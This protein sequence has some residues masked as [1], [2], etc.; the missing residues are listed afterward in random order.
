MSGGC[1]SM[2]TS[3]SSSFCVKWKIAH[4]GYTGH[5]SPIFSLGQVRGIIRSLNREDFWEDTAQQAPRRIRRNPTVQMRYWEDVNCGEVGSMPA[6]KGPSDFFDYYKECPHCGRVWYVPIGESRTSSGSG[7]TGFL[8]RP[9]ANHIHHC[10]NRTPAER[11]KI[12]RCD[13]ARWRKNPPRARIKNAPGHS[14]VR[15]VN[16]SGHFLGE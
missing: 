12:N 2:A 3:N 11:R 8:E 5:G 14:G 15:E 16:T 1:Q 13:E 9:I 10:K 6:R 4:T 7:W